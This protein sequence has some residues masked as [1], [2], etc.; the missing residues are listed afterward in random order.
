M[1]TK[2]IT[3]AEIAPLKIASLPTRP[4]APTAFGGKGY[5]STQ[6]K[7]AFDKLSLLIIERFNS[8]LDE[9]SSIDGIA[10]DIKTGFNDT[11]TLKDLFGEIKSGE[12]AAYLTVSEATLAS[13]IAAI[14]LEL[15]DI[16]EM[17]GG[18]KA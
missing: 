16:K 13:E 6:M 4:T 8:L 5:T 12:F 14:K 10:A 11:H 18:E 2:K 3:D 17:L 15:S 1:N 7:E 9:I